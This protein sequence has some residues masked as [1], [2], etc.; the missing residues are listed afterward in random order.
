[1]L[2]PHRL[3][4]ELVGCYLLIGLG[5]SLAIPPWQAPDEPAHLE[6][7][8]I[9]QLGAS[10]PAA[11]EQPIIA[12]LYTFHF[13]EQRRID[14]PVRVPQSL[15][16]PELRL[17]R[18]IDKAPGYYYLAAWVSSWTADPVLQLYSIRWLSVVLSALTIP[19]AYFTARQLLPPA[20]ARLALVAAALVAF[21]PMYAYIG[22][23]MNPDNLGAPLAAAAI[24]LAVGALRGRRPIPT[25][26]GALALA[27]LAFV[28][29]RST[30]ALVP[31]TLL[32]LGACVLGWMWQRLARPVALALTTLGGG[33]ALM[34]IAWPGDA[35]AGWYAVGPPWGATRSARFAY[36]GTHSLRIAYA[37]GVQQATLV[38]SLPD[39]RVR[40]LLGRQ[41]LLDAAVRTADGTVRGYLALERDTASAAVAP[42]VA[43]PRWQHVQLSY[44]V[45]I[46]TQHLYITLAAAS[47]G[48]LFFDRIRLLDG[49]TARPAVQL[50]NESAEQPFLWWQQR[51]ADRRVV[52]YV[53]RIIQ[54]ARDGVYSSSEARALYPLFLYQLFSSLY[55]R[56]GWMHFG[57]SD[58]FYLAVGLACAVL[59]SGLGRARRRA[60]GLE[61]GQRRALAWLALLVLMAVATLLLE[62][63][64]YLNARTYPQGRYLFPVLP[65]IACLLVSGCAQLLPARWDGHGALAAVGVLIALDLWSWAG[66]I[67]PFFYG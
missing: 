9:L 56:F 35:A 22:A 47:P 59:L 66:V 15:A 25:A 10:N 11:V 51:R 1:M 48:E 34:A 8:R 17:F 5:A 50:S 57:L 45:P 41:V 13:W 28:A 26:L 58:S 2:R 12:S 40:A 18:Q 33:V 23:A 42:F 20:R 19:L 44:T 32:A 60:S 7:A 67:V 55:G 53:T 21:L 49:Q 52:Q 63:T 4:L 37:A 14:P 24:L 30:I 61:A 16:A 3:L 62:Y 65:A 46:T 38:H 54:V 39:P 29:R 64:P 31:W 6:Y 27:V 43:T 36:E